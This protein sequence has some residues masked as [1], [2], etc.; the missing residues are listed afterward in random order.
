[1]VDVARA[2]DG[3]VVVGLVEVGV[4]VKSGEVD[5]MRW[6]GFGKS[7]WV[8]FELGL[9]FGLMNLSGHSASCLCLSRT[10]L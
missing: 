6:F 5:E 3:I 1:M 10:W 7:R 2:G 9:E 8:L 4:W